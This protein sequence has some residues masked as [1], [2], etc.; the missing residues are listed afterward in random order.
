MKYITKIFPHG[1]ATGTG[2]K[3]KNSETLKAYSTKTPELKLMKIDEF[4][5]NDVVY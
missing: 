2:K 4:R 5:D 1:S 3:T